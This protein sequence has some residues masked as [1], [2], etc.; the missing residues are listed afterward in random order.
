LTA[1]PQELPFNLT[2]QQIAKSDERPFSRPGVPH[3]VAMPK[4]RRVT[5]VNHHRQGIKFFDHGKDRFAVKQHQVV[6][7]PLNLA[8]EYILHAGDSPTPFAKARQP[9]PDHRQAPQS[10]VKGQ[11]AVFPRLN[12][13]E[14]VYMRRDFRENLLWNRVSGKREKRQRV[15]S[16]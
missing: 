4:R 13:Q 5:E 8:L 2:G 11:D 1:L 9:A 14:F 7:A 16:G 15:P 6:R 10:P 3:P 12:E